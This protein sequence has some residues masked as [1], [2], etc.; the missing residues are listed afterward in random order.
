V[1]S[2]KSCLCPAEWPHTSWAALRRGAFCEKQGRSISTTLDQHEK[3]FVLRLLQ[4]CKEYFH[5]HL[6]RTSCVQNSPAWCAFHPLDGLVRVVS[7]Y[8][9]ATLQKWEQLLDDGRLVEPTFSD[10]AGC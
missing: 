9:V 7:E 4:D 6:P 10:L 5:C 3:R 8:C 2:G 1:R